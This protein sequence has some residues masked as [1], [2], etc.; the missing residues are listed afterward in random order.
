[1]PEPLHRPVVRLRV[2]GLRALRTAQ[3]LL[4]ALLLVL[5]TVAAIAGS[6]KV[7]E[8]DDARWLQSMTTGLDSAS[9]SQ[10]QHDGRKRFLNDPLQATR[11]DAAAPAPVRAPLDS[12]EAVHMP[13]QKLLKEL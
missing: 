2:R 10:L 8:R 3:R 5:F 7:L 9:G 12:Y 6:Q 11:G 1:M 4:L 13:L